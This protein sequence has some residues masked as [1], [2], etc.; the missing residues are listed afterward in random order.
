[1]NRIAGGGALLRILELPETEATSSS[2]IPP[3]VE[4]EIV[5]E[6]ESKSRRCSFSSSWSSSL[7][8]GSGSFSACRAAWVAVAMPRKS[9]PSLFSSSP[10]SVRP[11]NI[12]AKLPEVGTTID[13]NDP[14]SSGNDRVVMLLLLFSVR[15]C[16]KVLK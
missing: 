15:R 13:D 5:V 2:I 11:A 6:S 14:S 7:L 4:R 3:S 16:M 12:T 9:S 8:V 1:M 10:E